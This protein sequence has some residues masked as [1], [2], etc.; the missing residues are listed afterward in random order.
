MWKRNSYEIPDSGREINIGKYKVAVSGYKKKVSLAI[1]EE[2]WNCAALREAENRF[3]IKWQF[4]ELLKG[5][6][7]SIWKMDFIKIFCKDFKRG[8]IER[9]FHL[10][11]LSVIDLN[12]LP[13]QWNQNLFIWK[14]PT[15]TRCIW[16]KKQWI[17]VGRLLIVSTGQARARDFWSIF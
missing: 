7:W 12:Q 6:S 9:K 17:I 16:Q 4:Q 5:L 1:C 10:V 2:L 8:M 3:H 14:D 13:Q 11:F 15:G